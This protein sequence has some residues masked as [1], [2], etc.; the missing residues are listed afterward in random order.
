MQWL[1]NTVSESESESESEGESETG[2]EELPK[3]NL[4]GYYCYVSFL[5]PC[6]SGTSLLVVVI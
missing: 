5:S 6:S 2:R 4:L 3:N 1:T